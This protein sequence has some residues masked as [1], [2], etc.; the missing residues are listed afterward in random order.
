MANP[1]KSCDT[2]LMLPVVTGTAFVESTLRSQFACVLPTAKAAL[3]KTQT[4]TVKNKMVRNLIVMIP[5]SF[6]VDDILN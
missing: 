2:A 1:C 5:S 6:L 4:A 3:L